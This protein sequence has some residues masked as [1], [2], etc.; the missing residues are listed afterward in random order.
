MQQLHVHGQPTFRRTTPF[1]SPA[2]LRALLTGICLLACLGAARAQAS[3]D[4]LVTAEAKE[5]G[6][7]ALAAAIVSKGKLMAVGTGGTRRIGTSIPVTHQ[8]RFHIGS[9]T[10]AMTSLLAAM[11]V[12]SGKLQWDSTLAQV[13]P[14]LAAGMDAGVSRVTLTQLLSH[15][16]GFPSDNEDFDVLLAKAVRQPGNLNEQRYWMLQQVATKPLAR[17]PGTGFAYSN[18]G[19]TLVGAMIERVGEKSWEELVVERVFKPLKLTSAGLGPQA[20]LGHI[21]APLGHALVDGKLKPMLGGPEA[22]NPL[23]ISPAGTA[24]M[25][26]L[27]FARWGS[28][29]AGQGKRAPFLVKPET[30]K[31]LV[32]PVVSMSTAS[33][34]STTVSGAA[35][36]A[37]GWASTKMGWT[38][39]PVAFHGGSNNMNKAYIWVDTERDATVVVMTNVATP[40]TDDVM[41]KLAGKLYGRYV[42]TAK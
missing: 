37:L 10:K 32:T 36:Y 40:N 24:H 31:K 4:A 35:Q 3:L 23:V 42:A 41:Q 38:A 16:S 29:M 20:T 8:D 21:D 1:T 39:Y 18:L 17:E 27:D 5:A 25:S 13:F 9:D 34:A 26:V 28:W 6:F 30:L 12:E 14:E 2:S 11:M 7:P 33:T 15:T 19:Y 22:D